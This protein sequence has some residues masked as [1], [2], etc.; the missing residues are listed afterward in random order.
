[1]ILVLKSDAFDEGGEIPPKYT[2]E[3]ANVSPGL[4]WQGLPEGTESLVLIVDD[5]DAPDPAAPRMVWDHW[6]LYNLP[7]TAA[8]LAEGVGVAALPTGCVAGLNSWGHTDYGGPCPP[9]GRHRYFHRLYALDTGL[10]TE[11]GNP[12]KND[13]LLAMEDHILAYTALVGTYRKLGDRF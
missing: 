1:M 5:P 6:I 7:P 4:Y 3:G 11:L 13:L 2:C 9:S 12:T 8:G 10:P